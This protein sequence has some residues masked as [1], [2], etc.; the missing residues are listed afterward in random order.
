MA[1]RF[2]ICIIIQIWLTNGYWQPKPGTTWQWQINSGYISDIYDVD[3]YD[4]DLFDVSVENITSLHSQGR[5]VICYFSA[6]SFENW[7]PDKDDFP[8]SIKGNSLGWPGEKWLNITDW[9]T[10]GPI[11]R[12]RLDMAVTKNCDGVEPDNVDGYSNNNGFS[13]TYADQI[14]YN[15]HL[16]TEAHARDLAIGLKN[17]LE[18][19][20]DLI[21][22]FDFAVNEECNPWNECYQLLNFTQNDKAVFGVEYETKVTDFCENMNAMNFDFLAKNWELDECVYACRDYPCESTPSC[23]VDI[24]KQ[25]TGTGGDCY[26]YSVTDI[27]TSSPTDVPTAHDSTPAPTMQDSETSEPTTSETEPSMDTSD[28]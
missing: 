25:Y 20:E 16:S 11:M 7:R 24:P 3:M 22:F 9:V 18:Q 27:P 23:L 28:V 1:P 26:D 2:Y 8:P 4:V 5:K 14:T 17:D 19:I 12:K 21:D 15:K 6:G 10:L 13:L